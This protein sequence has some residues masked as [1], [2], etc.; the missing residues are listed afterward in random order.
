MKKLIRGYLLKRRWQEYI[1]EYTDEHG[2]LTHD[3]NSVMKATEIFQKEN[4]PIISRLQSQEFSINPA[5]DSLYN[6]LISLEFQILELELQGVV[7]G[8]K[9]RGDNENIRL[10]RW[11]KQPKSSEFGEQDIVS[12]FF[13]MTEKIKR[14]E[15]VRKERGSVE[16]EYLE[17]KLGRIFD[18]YIMMLEIIGE[19]TYGN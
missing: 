19:L 2:V 14:L 13:L 18:S 9:A 7:S 8:T 15:R 5:V 11:C 12:G 4:A 6:L 17:R 16:P 3:W 1:E 10:D